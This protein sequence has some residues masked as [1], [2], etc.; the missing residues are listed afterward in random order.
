VKGGNKNINWEHNSKSA[1][2]CHP[3]KTQPDALWCTNMLQT[4]EG[5][6]ALLDKM[7]KGDLKYRKQKSQENSE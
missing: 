2:M 7:K 6:I 4:N 5:F 3:R 1:L